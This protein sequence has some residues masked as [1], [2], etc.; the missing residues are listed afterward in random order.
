MVVRGLRFG[1]RGFWVWVLGFWFPSCP[2]PRPPLPASLFPLPSVGA[3]QLLLLLLRM[4]LDDLLS[5][6][7]RCFFIALEV[8]LE[9]R[10][11]LGHRLNGARVAVQLRL[12]HDRADD[13]PV[14]RRLGPENLAAA[15]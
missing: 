14:V 10:P 9:E 6:F 8:P 15:R 2:T 4:L 1:V 7:I 13:G 5:D 11:P 12:R 3:G